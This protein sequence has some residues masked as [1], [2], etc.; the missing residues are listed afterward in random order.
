MPYVLL[1][2]DLR[3]A[4]RELQQGAAR[5]RGDGNA[6][7]ASLLTM[8]S[9]AVSGFSSE[10]QWREMVTKI[11]PKNIYSPLKN[12]CSPG[13]VQPGQRAAPRPPRHL[14][15]PDEQGRELHQRAGGGRAAARGQ[16][17]IRTFAKYRWHL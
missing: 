7:L 4:L 10:D 2:L 14:L 13:V 17:L 3:R 6:E 12:I 16:V 9:M 8:V 1:Q 5:A 11:W 15:L